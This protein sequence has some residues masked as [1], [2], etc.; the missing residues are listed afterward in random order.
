MARKNFKRSRVKTSRG[1][2]KKS[3]YSKE[4]TRFARMMGAVERG[5]RNS[6]SLIA[7]AYEQ[8]AAEREKRVKKSLF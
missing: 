1:G 5:R 6:D 4:I 3:S 7:S 2:S 8:G